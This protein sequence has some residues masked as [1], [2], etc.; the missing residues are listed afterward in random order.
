MTTDE[1]GISFIKGE[2]GYTPSPV[3]DNGH[4]M[5]GHGHD[6][7]PGEVPP[8]SVSMVEADTLLRT[9]L[10]TRYEPP[11]NRYLDQHGITL[12]QNQWNAWVDMAY[13]DGPVDAIT[14]ISHG[15]DQVP[16]QIMRWVYEHKNGVAVEVPGLKTRRKAELNLWSQV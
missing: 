2:E 16:V 9:D 6:Q 4:L 10:A 3:D 8:L 1:N 5:W 13:N 7:Q 11:L 14:M 15:V 12:T